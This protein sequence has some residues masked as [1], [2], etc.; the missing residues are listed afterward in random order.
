MKTITINGKEYKV[1]YSIRALM[2]FEQIADKNFEIVNLMDKHLFYYCLILASNKDCN[3][4]WDNFLDALD[5]DNGLYKEIE[6]VLEDYNKSQNKFPTEK[7]DE[8]GKKK[9]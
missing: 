2:L 7:T 4:E 8:E 3:L 9:V 6:K 1:K 5:E